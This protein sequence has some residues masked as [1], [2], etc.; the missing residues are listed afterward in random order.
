MI[1]NCFEGDKNNT[2][3]N[4]RGKKSLDSGKG[5]YMAQILIADDAPVMRRNIR[6]ILEKE[7]HQIVAEA[8]NGKQAYLEYKNYVPDL[9]TMDVNMPIV[10]GVEAVGNIVNEFPH[11]KIIMISSNDQKRMVFNA[12]QKGAKYYIMKPITEEK[13][14][15]VVKQF[16]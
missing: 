1:S 4:I 9:V 8:T 6:K 16:V 2:I 15:N 7:G 10:D 12:L 3:R 13:L 11:A 5:D 14:L